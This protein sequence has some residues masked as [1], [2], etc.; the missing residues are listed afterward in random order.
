MEPYKQYGMELITQIHDIILLLFTSL[1]NVMDKKNEELRFHKEKSAIGINIDNFIQTLHF[2]KI[3]LEQ[4]L[5]L[6]I[7]YLEFFHK[8][9]V[10]YLKRFTSKMN[11][12]TSQIN[13]DIQLDTPAKTRERRKTMLAEFKEDNIDSALLNQLADGLSVV[14]SDDDK[15]KHVI[16]EQDI[17]V[18]TPLT[19]SSKNSLNIQNS[20][21]PTSTELLSEKDDTKITSISHMFPSIDD[22]VKKNI[23]TP[24]NNDIVVDTNK[25]IEQLI[26]SNN[27][28]VECQPT[29]IELIESMS[30]K[31]ALLLEEPEN[32]EIKEELI[33]PLT[34][35]SDIIPDN[36]D[37]FD[38]I[39]PNTETETTEETKLIKMK[40]TFEAGAY[41]REGPSYSQ[42]NPKI[43]TV[44]LDDI[45]TL[46]PNVDKVLVTHPNGNEIE[47]VSILGEPAGWV[48][49]KKPDKTDVFTFLENE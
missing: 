46:T 8:L 16:E 4:K 35:L 14:D 9:H 10:K 42:E 22:N 24:S 47:W 33:S 45:V 34:V 19:K 41:I 43:G 44:D 21:K 37:N 1:K 48:P 31:G 2:E 38:E 39:D 15:E 11:L 5:V 12:I 26:S 13:H 3:V 36:E 23:V 6:F 30:S 32:E 28:A 20:Q 25:P 40:V 17:K 18:R 49:L 27:K 7:S 29:D